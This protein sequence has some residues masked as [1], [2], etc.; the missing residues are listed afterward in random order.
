MQYEWDEKKNHQN[1]ARHSFDFADAELFEWDR[2]VIYEDI[3]RQYSETRFIAYS[4]IHARL[5]VL[6]YTLRADCVRVIS[7]R[8][9]NQREV[10]QHGN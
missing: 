6:V 5:V 9:A 7:L 10:K 2:A 1:I 4:Y 3:R 8:K